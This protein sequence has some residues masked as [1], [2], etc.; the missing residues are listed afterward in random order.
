MKK[1]MVGILILVPLVVLLMVG[2][3]TTFVSVRA[4]I[5]VDEVILEQKQDVEFRKE[6]YKLDDLFKVTVLP[7]KATNKEYGWSLENVRNLDPLYD[8]ALLEVVRMLDASGKPLESE[9]YPLIGA[10]YLEIN[11]YCSFDVVVTAGDGK[12]DRITVIVTSERVTTVKL[13]GESNELRV[14]DGMMLGASFSPADSV[15]TD[16]VW[17]SSDTSVLVV[18]GNGVVTA[19]GEGTAYVYLTVPAGGESEGS[20]T[21]AGYEI[22]VSEGDSLFGG[23]VYVHENTF[24]LDGIGVDKDKIAAYDEEA[25][26]ISPDGTFTFIDG[27]SSCRITLAGGNEVVVTKC[28]ADAVVIE[29][30]DYFDRQTGNFVLSAGDL[31]LKLRAVYLSDLRRGENV[32][33]SHAVSWECSD[34]RVA[35]V[36]VNGVVYGVTGGEATVSLVVDGRTVSSVTVEV[37]KKVSYVI[38]DIS[39][40][41]LQST[42][43]GRE[44]VFASSRYDGSVLVDNS[45][46][47]GILAPYKLDTEDEDNFYNAFE[48]YAEEG[49]EKYVR[50]ENNRMYFNR[51]AFADT[52]GMIT[53]RVYVEAKYPKYESRDDLYKVSFSVNVVN[54]VQATTYNDM[55]TALEAGL[56][57]CLGDKVGETGKITVTVDESGKAYRIRSKGSLYGNGWTVEAPVGTLNAKSKTEPI[58]CVYS[59]GV[60]ISNVTLRAN[61]FD[62]NDGDMDAEIVADTFKGGYCIRF[63]RG[64]AGVD[65]LKDCRV[66]FCILENATSTV[67]LKGAEAEFEGCVIRNTSGVAIHVGN[68]GTDPATNQYNKLTM[69]NCVMSNMIGL[70]INFDYNSAAYAEDAEKYPERV[71]TFTQKGFLDIYN[72]NPIDNLTLLPD[73][74]LESELPGMPIDFVKTAIQDIIADSKIT[75]EQFI[76]YYNGVKQVHMGFM[77]MGLK[78]PQT[79]YPNNITMEDERFSVFNSDELDG[80]L[81]SILSQVLK[82]PIYFWCYNNK[83]DDLTPDSKYSVN[84]NLIDRLHGDY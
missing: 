1:I 52:E 25:A 16:T 38:L 81:G 66:E 46:T 20:V 68:E 53:F 47:I 30:A 74:I 44:T 45:L 33:D 50:F 83:V 75:R 22:T 13:G 62:G 3:V 67:Q 64:E 39:D 57:V 48:F 34:E 28:D 80:G 65:I 19:V 23:T 5:G 84:S 21:S 10:G 63:N 24:P 2:L 49:Y 72:W 41:L 79:L 31:P 4:E 11:G 58:I 18:D 82:E 43:V 32:A 71:S 77:A 54:G 59:G 14:G 29:N 56:D 42:G 37:Q 9:D 6:P 26:A 35:T 76:V 8:D 40:S 73:D 17:E 36:D 7:E 69:E 78:R 12:S 51:E 15:V 60:T 70:A 61:T 27:A 55:K